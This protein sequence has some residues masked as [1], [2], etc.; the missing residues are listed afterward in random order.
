MFSAGSIVTAVVGT[1]LLMVF[2]GASYRFAGWK[3]LARGYQWLKSHP[4]AF[5]LVLAGT[6]TVPIMLAIHPEGFPPLLIFGLQQIIF[7]FF[8]FL[9]TLAA[10]L[11]FW[12]AGIRQIAY[13]IGIR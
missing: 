4:G 2:M 1:L 11:A 3:S 12:E 13:W 5:F 7:A 10:G 6:A 8:F 9:G